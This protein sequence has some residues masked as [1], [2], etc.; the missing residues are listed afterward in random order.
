MLK[1][2]QVIHGLH[3]GGA[4]NVV[5]N[6]ARRADRGRFSVEICCLKEKGILGEQLEAEGIPVHVPAV[7]GGRLGK[8]R[9]LRHLVRASRP[10][11]LHSHGTAALLNIGPASL[12]GL[13]AP[14]LHTYHFGNYPH[15]RRSYLWGERIFSRRA[16]RCIAVSE[17]QRAAVL[18]YLHLRPERVDVVLNGVPD[19]PWRGD[20]AVRRA[21]RSEFGVS[22][23][24][25]LVG[26][27][28]VLSR[29][30]GIQ[31]LLHSAAT[32]ARQ[33]PR[34]RFLIAGGGPLEEDLRR[35]AA[36]VGLKDQIHFAG[37]RTDA[38]RLLA[39]LDVFVLPSLWEGLPMVLLEAMAT[40]LPVVVTDVADNARIIEDGISGRVVPPAQAAA[41]TAALLDLVA[42]RPR[43]R[44][45][46]EAARRAWAEHYSDRAMVA[47]YEA[48]YEQEA[49]RG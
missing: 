42:D 9:A 11:I 15:I 4:E 25:I 41:I 26:C 12:P 48:L 47:G 44:A 24:E 5:A 31:Y 46:G 20:A 29:Q 18:K 23:E 2:L 16:R 30:K 38:L 22:E 39:G 10:D 19:N 45:M 27:V 36:E 17:S 40:G 7:A 3:L 8:L 35:Q 13:P 49:R 28:A 33:E 37:W 14:L 6:I 43:A 1:V 21:I 34:L 32:L